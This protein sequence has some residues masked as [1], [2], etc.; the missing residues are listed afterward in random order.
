[1]ID[2]NKH[3]KEIAAALRSGNFEMTAA[4]ILI[5]RHG[6]NALANGAFKHTLYRGRERDIQIV[7]NVVINEWLTFMLN[8]MFNGAA[9]VTQWYVG[10]FSGNVTP[11]GATL[12]GA[13]MASALTE[14]KGYTEGNRL[15]FDVATTNTPSL[16]N[17]TN[18][19]LFEFDEDGPYTV[20]GAF[21]AQASAWDANSGKGF[22]AARFGAD[23]TGLN[24]PDKLGIEYVITAM[25]GGT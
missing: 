5:D 19:A 13:N 12:T 23:R 10:L 16:G 2:M 14:F 25:D 6:M 17:T 24:G 21:I 9:P 11:N 18:E 3:A 7:P 8:V 15:E 4:G 1:M 20:R 22:A